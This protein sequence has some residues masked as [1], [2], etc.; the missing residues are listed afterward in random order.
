M[1]EEMATSEVVSEVTIE[2]TQ[3]TTQE[4]AIETPAESVE[5]AADT[6]PSAETKAEKEERLFKQAEVDGIVQKR[7]ERERAKLAQEVSSHPALSYVS[8][9]AQQNNMSVE[10][11][12]AA[13][14][15]QDR[16]T[17][18]AEL[19]QT[20]EIPPE[21]AQELYESRQEKQARLEMQKRL[22][23]INE[24]LKEYPNL[25]PEDIP[26]SVWQETVKNGKSLAVAYAKYDSDRKDA[27]LAKL[28]ESLQIR[29][30]NAENAD[31]SPGSVTGSGTV[32]ADYISKEV[33][34]QNKNSRE[35]VKKNLTTIQ[36]SRSRWKG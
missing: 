36:K 12:I 4:T 13:C 8:K 15:Q 24:L 10:Q 2:P 17:Q 23:P 11:F 22:A 29:E 25:K 14:E 27:E 1:S 7:L 30:K 20:G 31:V 19:A 6:E 21:I 34:D 18:I 26:E 9:L 16:Q 5:K 32:P 33:F 28:K 35:W 3:E